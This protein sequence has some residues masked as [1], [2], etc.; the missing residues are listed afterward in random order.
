MYQFVKPT[1]R[2]LLAAASA[3]ALTTTAHA[4][5]I[6]G[7]FNTGVDNS[8]NALVGGNGMADPHYKITS[9]TDPTAG[10]GNYGVTYFNPAYLS[11]NANSRWI[12]TTAAGGGGGITRFEIT[13]DLTG[14]NAATAT[15]SGGTAADNEV[16][17][18]L[19]GLFIQTNNAGYGV[20]TPF[21]TSTGFISGIN[22]LA[23]QL[24]DPGVPGA[25]RVDQL[26][27]TADL[28]NVNPV[29]EPTSWALMIIGF[30][31]IGSTM[32]RR[33]TTVSY[34]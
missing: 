21:S 22:T 7:L 17:V 3:L 16:N 32:R 4:A 33:V 20:L 11:E 1:A 34:A 24:L 9:T 8:G 19:N 18:Y 28:G 14:F 5:A 6:V 13:F 23:F 12:S 29:P 2:T 30:G 27:G 25:L 26:R 10:V 15:I 31:V